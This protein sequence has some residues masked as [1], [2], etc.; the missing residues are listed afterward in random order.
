MGVM[1]IYADTY[2]NL[3]N[4]QERLRCLG[5]DT[6]LEFL[7]A[8]NMVAPQRGPSFRVPQ[9][10]AGP[11][12]RRSLLQRLIPLM[13]GCAEFPS[14][15]L[16]NEDIFIGAC[17]WSNGITLHSW[18]DIGDEAVFDPSPQT[19]PFPGT[20]KAFAATPYARLVSKFDAGSMA[21]LQCIFLVAGLRVSE[22]EPLHKQMS[23]SKRWFRNIACVPGGFLFPSLTTTRTYVH[24]KVV[25]E[26]IFSTTVHTTMQQCLLADALY[27]LDSQGSADFTKPEELL[28]EWKHPV[29]VESP[30]TRS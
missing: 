27:Q 8:P 23:K 7:A 6:T 19:V 29:R 30:V 14:D 16:Y 28:H 10:R 26:P 13:D 15:S 4:I 12:M 11:V 3:P 5:E 2:I 21:S 22:F 25:D 20:E 17:L 9:A 24:G 18:I 1:K